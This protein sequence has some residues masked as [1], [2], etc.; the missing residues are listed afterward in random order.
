MPT[1]DGKR[2][3]GAGEQ[4]RFGTAC[5]VM[6]KIHRSNSLNS[7]RLS[8]MSLNSLT[9]ARDKSTESLPSIHDYTEVVQGYSSQIMTHIVESPVKE[10]S[11]MI[12]QN[13]INKAKKFV[14]RT[15]NQSS[16]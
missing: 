14:L 4:V 5:D 2:A 8:S 6:E 12:E 10:K 3:Q 1:G 13:R 16:S 11:S 9:K 7:A 15:L